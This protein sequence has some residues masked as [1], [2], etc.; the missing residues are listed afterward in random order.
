M[1]EDP[2]Y[3]MALASLP[4]VGAT[5][6]R[7][8]IARFGGAKAAL[9]APLRDVAGAS[10]LPP[11][12]LDALEHRPAALDNAARLLA[13]LSSD[14]V[15]VLAQDHPAY[16]AALHELPDAPLLLYAVGLP[17]DAERGFAVAGSRS[18]SARALDAAAFAGRTLAEAGWTVVSGYAE[19]VDSAAH[20][21]A[22]EAGGST[23][24]LLPMGIRA[25]RLRRPFAP[26]R[27]ELGGRMVLLSECPPDQPWSA[28]AA[29]MRNRLIAAIGRAL[30]VVEARAN[31]GTMITFR[32]A[33]K[34][35]RPVYVI[36]YR[37]PL[38][39]AEGNRRAIRA[40]GMAV[41]DT[42]EFRAVA[43]AAT[44]PGVVPHGVQGHLF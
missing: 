17:S 9:D 8:L 34:L 11:R 41:A 12:A 14:G 18:A 36:D 6:A 32:S 42:G 37:P 40:G 7:E 29:V 30:L 24:L 22:L 13:D 19:G 25:F 3:W 16:P 31:G 23:W 28:R 5:S 39:E 27:A 4:G 26:Y 2:I 20:L 15:E 33:A 38:P 44:L 21:A 1:A 43:Q 35:G 10:A